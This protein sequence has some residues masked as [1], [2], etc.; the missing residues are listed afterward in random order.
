LHPGLKRSAAVA[1]T[2]ATVAFAG[3]IPADAAKPHAVSLATADS[4]IELGRVVHLHGKVSPAAAGRMVRIVDRSGA[5]HARAETNARGRFEVVL[6]PRRNLSVRATTKGASSPFVRL[7]VRARVRARLRRVRLFAAAR[8]VGRARPA[9]WGERVTLRWFR[10]GRLVRRRNVR[11]RAGGRFATRFRVRKPG[12]YRVRVT[13]DD[14]DHARGSD[15][16]V[17]RHTRLPQ[18]GAGARGA[19]VALLERRLRRLDYHLTGIDRRY[20]FRTTDAVR[21]FNKVQGRARAGDVGRSTWRALADPRRPR[22]QSRTPG[23][24]IEIDQTKQVL[25]TVRAGKVSNIL[26]TS[27][28]RGGITRDGVW[29]V[30]RKIDGYSPGRLYYPSYFDGL[31]AIHGWPEVPTSAASHGCARVPMWAARWIFAKADYGTV[32]RIYHS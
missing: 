23:F 19:H 24:H 2:A 25:Y 12:A 16:S 7:H 27:T 21:A 22:P 9:G 15:G 3:P 31:R 5:V 4:W 10:N 8:A 14:A 18:L 17:S 1:A 13:F 28:G 20:D 29:R 6:R 26:H 30:F 11:V 32:V